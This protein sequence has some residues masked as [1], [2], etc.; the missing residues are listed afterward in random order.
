M[1][2]AAATEVAAAVGG[3][4]AVVVDAGQGELV[5]L[6]QRVGQE[7][8]VVC[9]LFW[10]ERP[11]RRAFLLISAAV[12]ASCATTDY[13]LADGHRAA[14]TVTLV[15]NYDAFTPC[16]DEPSVEQMLA[17]AEACIRWGYMDAQAF[18]SVRNIPGP[19]YTGRLEM[20]FQC[21]GDLEN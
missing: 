8:S 17:A 12:A 19:E 18:G 20:V 2:A 21:V 13:F 6:A 15:C 1:R 10:K 4:G 16:P 3:L 14:G 5:D 11:M 7:F 9:S